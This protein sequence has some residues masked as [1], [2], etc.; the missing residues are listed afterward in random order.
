MGGGTI[1]FTTAC[2]QLVTRSGGQIPTRTLGN[3]GLDYL[4]T[5][6]LASF[7]NFPGNFNMQPGLK[8]TEPSIQEQES[9]KRRLTVN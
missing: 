2:R 6:R 4:D 9:C 8:A 5:G 1:C 7:Q 3:G